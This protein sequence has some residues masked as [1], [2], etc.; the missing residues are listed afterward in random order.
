MLVVLSGGLSVGLGRLPA[1]TDMVT[2]YGLF[3]ATNATVVPYRSSDCVEIKSRI[4][5]WFCDVF[6]SELKRRDK[7]KQQKSRSRVCS[8]LRVSE[9]EH[10]C[11]R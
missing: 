11:E 8:R 5:G 10:E 6:N 2:K 4:C 9:H 3:K 7:Q 1:R